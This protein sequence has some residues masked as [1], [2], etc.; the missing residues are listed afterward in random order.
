MMPEIWLLL[1]F[2]VATVLFLLRLTSAPIDAQPAT[3]RI[4]R[5]GTRA[6]LVS[7]AATVLTFIFGAL[8]S[9]RASALADANDSAGRLSMALAMCVGIPFIVGLWALLA[10]RRRR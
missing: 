10:L 5:L 4:A 9:L 3:R 8:R 2:Q 1:S 7:I 6:V